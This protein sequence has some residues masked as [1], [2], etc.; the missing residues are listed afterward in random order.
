MDE[1]PRMP[2]QLALLCDFFYDE[3]MFRSRFGVLLTGTCRT[4]YW[5]TMAWLPLA[6]FVLPFTVKLELPIR[7]MS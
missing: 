6:G 5:L 2:E 7:P 4:R 3:L 1:A